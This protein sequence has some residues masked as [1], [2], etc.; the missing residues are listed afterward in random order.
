MLIA[1]KIFCGRKSPNTFKKL[2]YLWVKSGRL[3][4]T[5]VKRLELNCFSIGV[6]F[7]GFKSGLLPAQIVAS[8]ADDADDSIEIFALN[9]SK[10][11]KSSS[12]TDVQ[13][14]HVK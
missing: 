2:I 9:P 12:A 5:K 11:D 13:V 4:A 6:L 10:I 14:E 7:K 8:E 1:K 3:L